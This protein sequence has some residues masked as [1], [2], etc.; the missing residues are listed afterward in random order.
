M[1]ASRRRRRTVRRTSDSVRLD[2]YP[3]PYPT[4]WYRLADSA[5]LRV[6]DLRYLECLGRQVVLWRGEDGKPHAMH[7]FCPHLG[8]NLSFGRIRGECIECPFHRWRFTGDGRAAHVPYS[9]H[10]PDGVLTE[11]FPVQ[12]VHGQVFMYHACDGVEQSVTDTPPYPVPR[13]PEIDEGTFLY[14]GAHDAGRVRMHILEFAENAV[15]L[16]HFEPIHNELRIPWTRLR[17]PGLTS[18]HKAKWEADPELPWR[19]HFR[20]EARLRVFGH[21]ISGSGGAARVTYHGPGSLVWFR[22]TVADWGDVALCQTHLPIGPLEQQVNFRW[23]ADR[24][25]PRWLVWYVTGNWISQWA[26]DIQI[27]ENKVYRTQPRLCPDDGPVFRLRRWYR[28]FLPDDLTV[29]AASLPAA[30]PPTAEQRAK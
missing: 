24:R 9:D 26:Q 30:T 4:G 23:F 7:A 21:P 22:I 27:W 16:A 14:R 11:T 18:E 8:A 12:E 2:S 17:I 25:L 19:M 10:I 29:V 5:S 20:D 15:D 6:G 3:H 13:I 1:R 28:Q